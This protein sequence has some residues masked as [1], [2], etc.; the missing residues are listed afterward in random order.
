M[1]CP[2]CNLC[3]EIIKV[4]CAIFRC[5]IVKA[6]GVQL[7][8]HLSEKKCNEMIPYIW[9]CSKPF[10]LVNGVLVKCDYI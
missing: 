8:S 7:P 4:N 10:K 6:T 9:G 1:N 2:H 5:G 3:I